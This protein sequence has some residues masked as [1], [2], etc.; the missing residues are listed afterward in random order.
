VYFQY[1]STSYSQ[2]WWDSI[3]SREDCILLFEIIGKVTKV[4]LTADVD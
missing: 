4:S 3:A 2:I 1:F